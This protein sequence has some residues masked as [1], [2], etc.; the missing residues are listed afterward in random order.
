VVDRGLARVLRLQRIGL[1]GELEQQLDGAS[2]RPR[3]DVA[4][5]GDHRER[6]LQRPRHLRLDE[7]G[8][9]L[10]DVGD[11]DDA[12][13][14]HLGVD[15]ARQREDRAAAERGERQHRDPDEGRVAPQRANEH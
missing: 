7:V 5:A 8:G 10:A 4:H 6:V 9:D 13:E 3:A 2:D 11:H 14:H 15:A 1:I 12:R